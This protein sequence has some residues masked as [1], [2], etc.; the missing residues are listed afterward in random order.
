MPEIS[1]DTRRPI[2]GIKKNRAHH[3]HHGGAWK[4]AYADLVTAMMS[5]FIV[6]WLM[7]TSSKVQ[8]AIAGYFNDPKGSGAQI[9]S[10]ASSASEI[11]SIDRGNVEKLKQEIQKAILKQA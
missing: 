9:G 8:K 10:A 2:I 1:K 7:N 4:V 11:V 3:G 6:L 5:L